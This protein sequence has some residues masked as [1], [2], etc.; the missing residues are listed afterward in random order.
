MNCSFKPQTTL[1]SEEDRQT[2]PHSLKMFC[3]VKKKKN[4]GYSLCEKYK[5][6]HTH[7][8][9]HPRALWLSWLGALGVCKKKKKSAYL[10]AKHTHKHT[11]T[12]RQLHIF[13][14][15][16]P[17]AFF[18]CSNYGKWPHQSAWQWSINSSST[19]ARDDHGNVTKTIAI[20]FHTWVNSK[21]MAV[22]CWAFPLY[23]VWISSFFLPHTH[24]VT[25]LFFFFF[26]FLLFP[27]VFI[28]ETVEGLAVIQ[29]RDRR[30]NRKQHYFFTLSNK[31]FT[32]FFFGHW[33]N[34]TEIIIFFILTF[35]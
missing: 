26:F 30:I 1:R 6:T 4:S 12:L 14:T 24:Y 29:K 10:S 16:C 27:C 33:L 11:F 21:S 22:W 9:T 23:P 15:M 19:Q 32:D 7:T 17:F 31:D 2:C 25:S 18:F 3:L 28:R 13:P 35:I 20:L 8:H 34:K 5:E